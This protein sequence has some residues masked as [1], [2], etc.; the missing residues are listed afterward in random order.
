LKVSALES[1]RSWVWKTILSAAPVSLA[2]A[3][4][5]RIE[6][7]AEFG[8]LSSVFIAMAGT[9]VALWALW[10]GRN[11]VEKLR[12]AEQAHSQFLAAA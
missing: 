12:G 2:V 10:R 9:F 8:R 11:G 5:W 7:G 3:G 4:I 1:Q 6:H